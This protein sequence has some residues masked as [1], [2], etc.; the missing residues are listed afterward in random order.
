[1]TKRNDTHTTLRFSPESKYNLMRLVSLKS[2][3][4]TFLD[5]VKYSFLVNTASMAMVYL[6]QLLLARFMGVDQYGVY[7]YA[8][9]WLNV[10]L[11]FSIIGLD[12]AMLRFIPQYV[13]RGEWGNCWGI[14]KRSYQ[15]SL[16]AAL[17]LLLGAWIVILTN[18]NHLSEDLRNTLAIGAGALPLWV[19]IK[20]T[21]GVLQAFKRPGMS[22]LLDGVLLPVLLLSLLGLVMGLNIPPSAVTV[23]TVFAVSCLMVLIFGVVWLRSYVIPPPMKMATANY[24]TREWLMFAVPMLMIV[25]THVIMNNSDVI[26]VGY[27]KSPAQAG[28]Y[29]A[30]ARVAALV[31]VS[32]VFV[33]MVLT[34]YIS[35]YYYNERR[36]DLQHLVSV[37]ARIVTLFAVPIFVILTIYGKH[38]LGLFG[39]EFKDGY[40]SLL[41]LSA[42]Q[43][44]NALSGSVGYIMIL[45]GKQKQAAYVLGVCATLN[46]ILNFL[47]IPNYGIEGAALATALILI[48]W[49]VTLA[50]YIKR[51]INLSSTI[52]LSSV[53][54]YKGG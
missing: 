41:I 15:I 50:I 51:A 38:I 1:M 39:S 44:V 42:G 25:G 13:S 23:M 24:K 9:S 45:T 6:S 2:V 36:R 29:S 31:S 27:I 46:I 7:V 43:L 32:L 34:P 30:A 53:N 37:S 8:L 19:A 20:L 5:G 40:Y 54:E 3:T 18:Y 4:R 26:M 10:L 21:Q 35:E 49:N 47:L 17:V 16:P 33:N 14:I 11:L 12:V 28:I 22:Q 48:F 52:F